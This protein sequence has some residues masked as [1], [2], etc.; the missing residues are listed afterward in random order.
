MNTQANQSEAG[1]VY[2]VSC[3]KTKRTAAAAAKDLY[4]SDW[5]A[6]ARRYVEARHSPW[7]ILS[8]KYGLV[9]PDQR[10]E[11]YEM[12][13]KRMSVAE[14]RRWADAVLQS[15]FREVPALRHAIFLAG[16]SYREFLGSAL[17]ERGVT[18]EVP[19]EG[20]GSGKQLQWLKQYS[21]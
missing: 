11:P 2:F 15:I 18:T 13:L 4:V 12:T 8:A 21:A 20:L 7:F 3:V 10:I 14:R 19:M 1:T 17:R 16:R 5:F 9:A 6:K